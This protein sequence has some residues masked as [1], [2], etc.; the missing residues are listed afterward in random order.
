[1][2]FL[3]SPPSVGNYEGREMSELELEHVIRHVIDDH[4]AA[5]DLFT[6]LPA[7]KISNIRQSTPAQ[8]AGSWQAR[9]DPFC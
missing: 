4:T 1:M 7:A 3:P 8:W 9:P 5:K 6:R 2:P